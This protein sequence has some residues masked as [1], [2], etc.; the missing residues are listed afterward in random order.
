VNEAAFVLLQQRKENTDRTSSVCC[1]QQKQ[2]ANSSDKSVRSSLQK[3][4]LAVNF[5]LLNRMKTVKPGSM[6]AS[7]RN[8]LTSVPSGKIKTGIGRQTHREQ[9][10]IANFHRKNRD[11]KQ[12]SPRG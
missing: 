9:K 3:V 6:L 10:N 12:W 11:M 1:G 7:F 2:G 8:N 5:T 4:A